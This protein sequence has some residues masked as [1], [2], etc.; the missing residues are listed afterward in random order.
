LGALAFG[1]AGLGAAA[2][3]LDALESDDEDFA[4]DFE[5]A[6]LLSLDEPELPADAALLSLELA[7]EPSPFEVEFLAAL[8]SFFPSLP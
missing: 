3:E 1:S 5:S 8:W 6:D 2:V 7:E 4:P